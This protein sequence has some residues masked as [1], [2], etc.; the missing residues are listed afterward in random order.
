[1][2]GTPAVLDLAESGAEDEVA[3]DA[4]PLLLG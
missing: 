4:A 1:L 3:C 2:R